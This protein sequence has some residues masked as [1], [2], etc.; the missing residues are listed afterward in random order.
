MRILLFSSLIVILSSFYS[1][2]KQT[3]YPV[4][5]IAMTYST[6]SDFTILYDV[7]FER[8][9]LTK[10]IDTLTIGEFNSINKY[11]QLLEFEESM[12]NHILFTSNGKNVDT[13]TD[14]HFSRDKCDDLKEFEYRFNGV[15]ST[16]NRRTVD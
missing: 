13:I 9:G 15:F 4:S 5:G 16:K 3:A 2:C 6:V 11:T 14:V 10:V 7:R 12:Y 8:G 1:C